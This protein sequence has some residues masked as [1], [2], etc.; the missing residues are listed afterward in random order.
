MYS[1]KI[2]CYILQVGCFTYSYSILIS[3]TLIVFLHYTHCRPCVVRCGTLLLYIKIIHL[4]F[5]KEKCFYA[6]H[7]NVKKSYWKVEQ[8]CQKEGYYVKMYNVLVPWWAGLLR[9]GFHNRTLITFPIND[10]KFSHFLLDNALGTWSSYSLIDNPIMGDVIFYILAIE[11]VIPTLESL[12]MTASITLPNVTMSVFGSMTPTFQMPSV[13]I[14]NQI[15]KE[16]I[17]CFT[18]HA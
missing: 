2:L 8:C 7:S 6:K 1:V 18:V 14:L 11:V 12:M 4:P 9:E 15:E 3:C 17:V 5:W 16:G 10:C 13:V